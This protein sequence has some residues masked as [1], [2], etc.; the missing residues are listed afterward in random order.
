MECVI[1]TRAR[2][3]RI[4]EV[5]STQPCN[6]LQ[7]SEGLSMM[8]TILLIAVNDTTIAVHCRLHRHTRSPAAAKLFCWMP[9]CWMAYWQATSAMLP[10]TL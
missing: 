4:W 1:S 9:H 3:S 10:A 6:L 7:G 2:A 5:R 8:V